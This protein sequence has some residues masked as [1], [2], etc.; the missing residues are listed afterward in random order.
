MQKNLTAFFGKVAAVSPLVGSGSNLV[1]DI[2]LRAD[3]LKED[4]GVSA[5]IGILFFYNN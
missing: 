1:Q 2:T 5:S 3:N 4:D